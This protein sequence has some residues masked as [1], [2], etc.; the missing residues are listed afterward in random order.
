MQPMEFPDPMSMAA[1]VVAASLVG[2]VFGMPARALEPVDVRA[3][4]SEIV[5]LAPVEPAGSLRALPDVGLVAAL[6]PTAA[7]AVQK[8]WSERAA[9]SK[10][11]EQLRFQRMTLIDFEAAATALRQ[12]DSKLSITY[13]PDPEQQDIASELLQQQGLAVA[14][15]QKRS[16][17]EIFAFCPD[18]LVRITTKSKG[19]AATTVVPCAMD[20]TTIAILV[21]RSRLSGSSSAVKAYSLPE[22]LNFLSQQSGQDAQNMKILPM[23]WVVSTQPVQAAN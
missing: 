16:A 20:F 6:S 12:K 10:R 1:R 14:E 4:F 3:K 18:P 7:T 22:L 9:S 15:A 2:G 8:R 19:G 5:V 17:R 13:V 21:N 11:Q 23:P